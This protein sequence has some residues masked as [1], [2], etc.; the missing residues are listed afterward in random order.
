[1]LSLQPE[2]YL[3]K[4]TSFTRNKSELEE[5]KGISSIKSTFK[6]KLRTLYLDLYLDTSLANIKESKDVGSSHSYLTSEDS[7][8]IIRP[9][10]LLPNPLL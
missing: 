9:S 5:Y 7:S 1:M 2:N 6:Q 4:L 3:S 10:V 8:N